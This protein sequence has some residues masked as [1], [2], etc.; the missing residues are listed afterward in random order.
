M[1]HDAAFGLDSEI[2]SVSTYQKKRLKN[3]ITTCSRLLFSG[4]NFIPSPAMKTDGAA[5]KRHPHQWPTKG[6]L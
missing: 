1:D 4:C 3:G 2:L 6:R 5:L